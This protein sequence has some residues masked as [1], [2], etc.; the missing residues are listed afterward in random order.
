MSSKQPISIKRIL[1]AN[2]GEIAVRI[3]RTC[4]RMGI[5]TVA[6]YSDADAGQSF[7]LEA[8]EAIRI[9]GNQPA[10]SY[11]DQEKVITA[12]KQSSS[13][14]IHPGYGFLSENASF[15]R[16]CAEENIIFIGPNPDAI[17]AMGS[18][19]EAKKIMEAAEV[20]VIPGYNGDQQDAGTL[21]AEAKKIGFPVLLKASAGGG[22]KGMRVVTH[23]KDL[24]KSIVAAK[25]EA[26]NA[27]DDDDLLIEK[28]FES[29]RHIEIQIFG[30]Q[31][32]N[33][34]HLGER[35]C[36]IQR[37]HQKVI[38]ECP[39]PILS[40]ASRNDMGI[41]ALKAA[42]A[43]QYDNAGTVEFIYSDN[44]EFYFL[45]VNTRLQ[46]EHPV[47]EM[48]TG[49]DLVE[50][51]I[52]IAMGKE[53]SISQDKVIFSG[54]AMECRLYAEDAGNDFLPATGKI[55]HWKS[56]QI[57]GVR[58]DSGV[59]T[60]SSVGVFYDPMIAKIIAHGRNR[61]ETISKLQYA[62]AQLQIA[63]LT[64]NN[65]FLQQVLANKNFQ[66]GDFNT[67]FLHSF[68]YRAGNHPD[69]NSQFLC[70][71]TC[72]DILNR[73]S[74]R[75]I[76]QELPSGW[77]NNYYQPQHASYGIGDEVAEIAFRSLSDKVEVTIEDRTHHLS[78]YSLNENTL[79]V[80][81]DGT[82]RAFT[83]VEE[84]EN[85]YIHCAAIGNEV[86]ARKPRFALASDE[87]QAG[88]YN[89]PM[90]GQVIDVMVKAGDKV[91]KGDTLIIMLSMKMENTIEAMEDGEVEE[92]FVQ[93]DAFV[94]ADTPLIKINV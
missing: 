85:V 70:A 10:E 17:I 53:L 91:K 24:E 40:E 11:L 50:M 33:Y 84:N 9:G 80:E 29:S 92:V 22:G 73:Q 19:I 48:V 79:Q 31:H 58:Y 3:M 16:R 41:A 15:A 77:R 88:G 42:K 94:E 23:E 64:T 82:N 47:T 7:V 56:A 20:P 81:I 90:P 63:G 49:L 35:E 43:I 8:D 67:H 55:L 83:L 75:K 69:A 32:Q 1:I 54:H 13:D 2:R 62:M 71:A 38:E 76:L 18:K 39:S 72:Y 37:R 87:V 68:E 4:R 52:N 45:E 57:D 78:G 51:Q 27:F 74:R 30:D 61:E 28:Y 34:I 44:G 36:S 93:K 5:F 86:V 6:I 14:A 21:T 12:A 60:T 66:G 26:K 25:R 65:S 46:V 59:R 89:A